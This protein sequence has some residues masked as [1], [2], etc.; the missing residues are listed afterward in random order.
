MHKYVYF[1]GLLVK[2]IN[3]Y[4]LFNPQY[5]WNTTNVGIQHQSIRLYI[6]MWYRIYVIG[7]S[8]RDGRIYRKVG[9]GGQSVGVDLIVEDQL[10]GVTGKWGGGRKWS[11]GLLAYKPTSVSLN[12]MIY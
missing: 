2:E 6:K 3:L 12:R 1:Y 8:L 11:F 10:Q 9:G 5:T 4:N 7:F